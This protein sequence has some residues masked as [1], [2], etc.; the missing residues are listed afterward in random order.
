MFS[1]HRTVAA[2]PYNIVHVLMWIMIILSLPGSEMGNKQKTPCKQDV[3]F[4]E[5]AIAITLY[6][7][8]LGDLTVDGM[9]SL[10][11]R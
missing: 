5:R 6:N 7:W 9:R 11:A 8:T 10:G 2:V 4:W 1:G 3:F